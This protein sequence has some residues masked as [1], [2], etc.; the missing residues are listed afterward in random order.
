[1]FPRE[2]RLQGEAFGRLLELAPLGVVVQ[3][4]R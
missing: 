2:N 4:S 3:S 1:M